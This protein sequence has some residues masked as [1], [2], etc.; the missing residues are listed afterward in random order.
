MAS[1]SPWRFSR[2][3]AM[4]ALL[5]AGGGLSAGVVAGEGAAGPTVGPAAVGPVAGG[6]TADGAASVAPDSDRGDPGLGLVPGLMSLV[7]PVRRQTTTRWP[8]SP[9]E[10]TRPRRPHRRCRGRVAA[11]RSP[12]GRPKRAG[13]GAR[14]TGA[15]ATDRRR[16]SPCRPA[17]RPPAGYGMRSNGRGFTPNLG[18]IQEFIRIPRSNGPRSRHARLATRPATDSKQPAALPPPRP[19]ALSSRQTAALMTPAGRK[20]SSTVAAPAFP[21]RVGV[22]SNSSPSMVAAPSGS[23]TS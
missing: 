14:A 9:V 20:G 3:R 4:S 21:P 10:T 15:C 19:A 23:R 11:P 7:S 2:Y 18:Q 6:G 17:P 12:I 13:R 16:R 1:I 5:G 8:H 22:V